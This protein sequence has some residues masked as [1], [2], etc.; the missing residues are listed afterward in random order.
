MPIAVK[1]N[2]ALGEQ[3]LQKIG[4]ERVKVHVTCVTRLYNHNAIKSKLVSQ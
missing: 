2:V 3:N 4:S 1:I